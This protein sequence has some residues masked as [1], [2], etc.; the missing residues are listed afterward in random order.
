MSRIKRLIQS[1]SKYVAVPWRDDAAARREDADALG[2]EGQHDGRAH[3][4]PLRVLRG[5]VPLDEGE[6]AAGVVSG[7]RLAHA[8]HH[9]AEGLACENSSKR[10]AVDGEGRTPTH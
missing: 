6:G 2:G 9:L 4:L 7:E 8:Q 5:P 10:M 1:Y 3:Q